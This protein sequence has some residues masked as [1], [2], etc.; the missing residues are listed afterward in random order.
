MG[1]LLFWAYCPFREDLR[2][3]PNAT[4]GYSVEFSAKREE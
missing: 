3:M 2:I 4:R 1:L